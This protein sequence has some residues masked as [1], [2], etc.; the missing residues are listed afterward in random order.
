MS[1]TISLTRTHRL[2]NA[3]ALSGTEAFEVEGF[4]GYSQGIS[5][6]TEEDTAWGAIVARQLQALT[7]SCDQNVTVQFLGV[8]YA[9]LATVTVARTI[10][11]TGDLSD[12]IEAGDIVRLEGTVAQDG[13]YEV[14][15][16]A[17]VSPATTI[18]LT[19]GHTDL[20]GTGAVGTFAKVMSRQRYHARYTTATMVAGTGVITFAGDVSDIFSAGDY[21]RVSAATAN[22]GIF[23]VDSVAT[24]GPP[25]TVTTLVVNGGTLPDSNPGEF[26]KIR[27]SIE[28]IANV[29]YLWSI[30]GGQNNPLES[31]ALHTALRGDVA[32]L[33]VNNATAVA[34]TFEL[35]A[36]VATNLL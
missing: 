9:I 8:R 14:L 21:V 29:P 30:E 1:G 20:T 13:L 31:E 15:T 17:F 10:T 27:P 36:G 23:V 2:E 24:D 25:V 33:A 12:I 28:L 22:N 5:A 6:A 16:A 18:T 11:F 7:M 4:P 35:R 19:T 34:A 3:E 26:G 32:V